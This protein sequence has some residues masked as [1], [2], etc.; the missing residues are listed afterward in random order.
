MGARV[1]VRRL[2][3]QFLTWLLPHCISRIWSCASVDGADMSSGCEPMKRHF[4]A[5]HTFMF[6]RQCF[7]MS[8]GG[9]RI[10][11]CTSF[12]AGVNYSTTKIT[13][14]MKARLELEEWIHYRLY[15][16]K[17]YTLLITVF[18]EF[19]RIFSVSVGFIA[20]S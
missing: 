5:M 12:G 10:S 20:G 15:I 1:Y 6:L 17:I 19:K 18:I 4:T 16:T 14:F 9:L 7:L 13:L 3:Y 11:P 8:N 2:M